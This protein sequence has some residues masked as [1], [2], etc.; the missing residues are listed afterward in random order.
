MT[1]VPEVHICPCGNIWCLTIEASSKTLVTRY[2]EI[3]AHL[4]RH[5]SV[6]YEDILEK[7]GNNDELALVA[8]QPYIKALGIGI[9]NI[10]NVFDP[11][12]VV[13]FGGPTI[14]GNWLLTRI[15]EDVDQRIFPELK[16]ENLVRYSLLKD[17]AGAVGA[18][19]LAMM[20]SIRRANKEK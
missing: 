16:K 6:S 2:L 3:T 5:E 4:H 20:S 7:A 13:L 17:M 10:I 14:T 19:R 18:A 11:E 8:L 1:V 15:S 12:C 9:G